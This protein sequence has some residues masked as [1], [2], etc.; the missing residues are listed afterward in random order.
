MPLCDKE[1]NKNYQLT[2]EHPLGVKFQKFTEKNKIVQDNFIQLG[3]IEK[4]K[5]NYFF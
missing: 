2:Q 4:L 1:R 3:M 5:Q